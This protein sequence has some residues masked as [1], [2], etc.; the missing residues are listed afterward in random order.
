MT[1]SP[2]APDLSA[3]SPLA[4]ELAA[5]IARV[6]SDIAIVIDPD[7]VI[8]SVSQSESGLV[9]PGS[10]WVGQRWVDTATDGT[11]RKIEMLLQ[12]VQTNGVTR[13]RE[14][15]HPSPSGSEI[16]MTWSAIRL[17]EGGPVLAVGRDLRAVAAIQQRLV[18]AQQDLERQFWQ[19]RQSEARYRTLFQ[20]ASDG[21]AV[22]QAEDLVLIEA[23]KAFG[24]ALGWAEP[25]RAQQALA[26]WLPPSMQAAVTE[27]LCSARTSG[28]SGEIRVRAPQGRGVLDVAAT[29]FRHGHERQ[30]MLR[31]RHE[32][33]AAAGSSTLA[34]MA[35][36][37]ES[38]PDA[39][40]MTDSVGRIQMA[41]PAFL[42]LAG[43]TVENQALGRTLSDMLGPA[44]GIWSQL[45]ERTNAVGM[46]TRVRVRLAAPA[47]P[48]R[49]LEATATLMTEGEQ[50][51]LGFTLRPIGPAALAP[52]ALFPDLADIAGRVGELPLQD[53]LAQVAQ[54]AERLLILMA[55]QRA[56]GARTVAA[57]LLGLSM[58]ELAGRLNAHG[59]TGLEWVGRTD[60]G[61]P[62]MN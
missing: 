37:V 35:E 56:E 32:Q 10:G 61:P 12:E 45:I 23:N 59:L 57:E 49:W 6:A 44:E 47:Q 18:D 1:S 11:R 21:V 20:V 2:L 39:V 31:L 60:D 36:F 4:P 40:V 52:D 41:N 42:R 43:V 38:T 17:G 14:V 22:L 34:V 46:A 27:L 28:R 9:N 8:C 16:P 62:L 50:A 33:G 5:T 48:A 26:V 15:N 24:L 19:R 29:L 3:L 54:R 30:L 55:L 7:G 51:C 53:L 13:R 58:S 25:L